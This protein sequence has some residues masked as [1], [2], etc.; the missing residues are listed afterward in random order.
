MDTQSLADKGLSP[1][2]VFGACFTLASVAGLANLLRANK[3]LNMRMV[4]AATLYSGLFGL[5]AGLIWYNYFAPTNLYFLIGMSGLAGLGGVSL[6]DLVVL[7]I[8]KGVNV[9]ITFE[10]DDDGDSDDGK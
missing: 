5:V 2:Q 10:A 8:L 4:I 3:A 7:L 6:L 1:V 9:R